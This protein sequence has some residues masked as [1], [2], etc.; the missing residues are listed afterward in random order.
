MRFYLISPDLLEGSS[1]AMCQYS[2]RLPR[3]SSQH[4]LW[5]VHG[6]GSRGIS[7]LQQAVTRIGLIWSSPL[8]V[9]ISL[10]FGTLLFYHASK[11]CL[12]HPFSPVGHT[13]PSAT[14]GYPAPSDRTYLTGVY[15]LLSTPLVNRGIRS[16][17]RFFYP[18][19][20]WV[21]PRC[22]LLYTSP[23]PRD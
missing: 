23:S 18:D 5:Q 10:A 1:G 2:T 14:E 20:F 15:S 13:R 19:L 8:A 17:S 21:F 7:Q 6:D 16:Y 3:D 4:T 22:C 12:R 9:S 11:V